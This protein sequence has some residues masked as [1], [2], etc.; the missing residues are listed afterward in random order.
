MENPH[1]EVVKILYRDKKTAQEC[2]LSIPKEVEK[3]EQELEEESKLQKM[4]LE[5]DYE[6]FVLRLIQT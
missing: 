2:H 5:G 3:K 4:E 1:C 6:P